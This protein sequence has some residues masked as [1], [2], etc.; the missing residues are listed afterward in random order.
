MRVLMMMSSVAMGGAEQI[1][2][3]VLPY[4]EA[5]GITP[6]L[7]TLNTRRDSPITERLAQ[8]G[9]KRFDLGAR[10]MVD[11]LA[12]R[13]FRRL[14]QQEKIDLLNTQDQD[15]HIYGGLAGWQLN[16]P[17]VM[18]RHVVGEPSTTLKERLRARLVLL[19]A[20]HG[21]RRLVAVS[22]AV[23]QAFARQ[24]GVPLAKIDTIHNGID[25]QKFAT[26]HQRQSKRAELGWDPDRPIVIM[27]AVLRPGKGHE[28]LFEALPHLKAAL[29]GVQVK[30]VGDGALN[31]DLRQQAAP[32]GDTVEF[33]G[34]RIDVPELLGASDVLVLPSWSEALP[35]VLLEAGAASLPVVAT[36]VGGTSEI[37]VDGQTGFIVPPGNAPALAGRLLEVLENPTRGQQMGREARARVV[38]CFS[39]EEQAR[40]LAALFQQEVKVYENLV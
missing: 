21:A 24:A 8:T 16:M 5:A 37:V 18:T 7:C 12:W 30:L 6:L 3:S 40:S 1:T 13:R 27:V 15:T 38:S 2:V 4:L 35:T 11:P 36:D 10:R 39:L 9:V 28:L 33:L 14:L 20:R 34:Q 23:R 29:P 32:F 25:V 17:V 19:A 31:D 26:R 22:D